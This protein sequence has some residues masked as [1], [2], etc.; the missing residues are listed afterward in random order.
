[1][2]AEQIF[3]PAIEE[4]AESLA[5]IDRR[6][7]AATS[8]GIGMTEPKPDRPYV[9]WNELASRP[10]DE[11]RETSNS[12]SRVYTFW[13]YDDMGDTTRINQILSVIRRVC[14]DLVPFVTPEGARCT[15]QEYRGR[16]ALVVD[17][18]LGCSTR[19]CIVQ[20]TLSE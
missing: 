9:V 6:I 4:D 3:V 1:M 8:L 5:L 7:F 19:F 2:S 16:G 11:V 15:G 20:F 14:K 10:Y 13:A 17:D 12:E 18:G